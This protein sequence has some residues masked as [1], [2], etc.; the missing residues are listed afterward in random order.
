MLRRTHGPK[1]IFFKKKLV[2][3]PLTQSCVKSRFFG[4][5]KPVFPDIFCPLGGFFVRWAAFFGAFL[6]APRR[7]EKHG[8]ISVGRS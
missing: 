3:K 4:Y 5:R 2:K 8:P 1:I 7:A 6:E